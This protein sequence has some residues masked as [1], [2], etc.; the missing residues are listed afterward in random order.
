MSLFSYSRS[1]AA[2]RLVFPKDLPALV[3]INADLLP[4]KLLTLR[5]TKAL[6]TPK[7]EAKPHISQS[8]VNNRTSTRTVVR[9]NSGHWG[10]GDLHSSSPT[11][12]SNAEIS[13]FPQCFSD[14]QCP[15]QHPY[16]NVETPL[17]PCTHHLRPGPLLGEQTAVIRL[18]NGQVTAF[19]TVLNN[20]KPSQWLWKNK[21]LWTH[22]I[23]QWVWERNDYSKDSGVVWT[24]SENSQE[25]LFKK[26]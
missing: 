22:M 24:S 15:Y 3:P 13:A 26:Q 14:A 6:N 10:K 1:G 23:T 20:L 2:T 25:Q 5:P 16:C 12:P 7:H 17:A 21:C 11:T 9:E 19:V 8:N 18:E 4:K